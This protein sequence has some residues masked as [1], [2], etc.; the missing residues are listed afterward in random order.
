VETVLRNNQER[1]WETW[2]KREL[3]G[4]PGQKSALRIAP[5]LEKREVGEALSTR[6]KLVGVLSL[7]K[8]ALPPGL[9]KNAKRQ[10]RATSRRVSSGINQGKEIEITPV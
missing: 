4:K 3:T 7:K 2:G 1:L 5:S 6:R 8:S 10:Q 9:S